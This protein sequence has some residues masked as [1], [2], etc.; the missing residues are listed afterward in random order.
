LSERRIR[1]VVATN[2]DLLRNARTLYRLALESMKSRMQSA[3]RVTSSVTAARLQ[4]A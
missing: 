4:V 2:S 3:K 1:L